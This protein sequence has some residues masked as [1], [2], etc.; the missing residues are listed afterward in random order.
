MTF[1]KPVLSTCKRFFFFLMSFFLLALICPLEIRAGENLL[2]GDFSKAPVSGNQLPENWEPLTF[3]KIETHTRYSLADEDGLTVIKAQSRASASGLIRKIRIDPEKYPVIQWRWKITGIYQK[4]D[5]TSKSGDDYPARIYITFEYDP[6][7]VG[8]LEKAKFKAARVLYGEYPPGSAINYIWGSLAPEGPRV[9]NPY[10]DRVMMIVIESG[11]EMSGTWITEE[12]NIYQ[13]YMNSFGQAPP[14]ISGVAVMT[15]SDNTG[16]AATAFYGD[17]IFKSGAI[18][19][20]SLN[21]DSE[22]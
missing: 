6:D 5:V 22:K 21:G 17:I 14:M 20:R 13:D 8:L 11:L 4:G 9:P 10:T 18:N 15:D 1:F 19:E 2:I 3:N 16:E 12:R 7:R